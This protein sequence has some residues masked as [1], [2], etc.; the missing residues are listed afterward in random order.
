MFVTLMLAGGFAPTMPSWPIKEIKLQNKYLGYHTD[1]LLVV[2]EEPTS[3]K[4]ARLLAHIKKS[5][6]ITK[7]DHVFRDVLQDAWQDYSNHHRFD[8]TN[9]NIS[10]ITG[11]LSAKDT[12][13]VSW[14]LDQARHTADPEEFFRK[15]KETNFSSESK[16]RKLSAFRTH[17]DLSQEELH[18]FMNRFHLLICDLGSDAGTMLP[19]LNSLISQFDVIGPE[20]V[21]SRIVDLVQAWNQDA[22]TITIDN[23]PKELRESFS[24][25][26]EELVPDELIVPDTL[27]AESIEL[28]TN[29]V[30]G[31]VAANLVGSWND[32]RDADLEIIRKLIAQSRR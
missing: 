27:K 18:S 5:I 22:G 4:R 26:R 19:L 10:L 24:R 12:T 16:R 2:T 3:K 14:L 17:L 8:R 28:P 11:L 1:D 32:K 31:L 6:S 29:D 21:W 23:L 13:D 9:D 30:P 20:S 25:K 15:V 7:S